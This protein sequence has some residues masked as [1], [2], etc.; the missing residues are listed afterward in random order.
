M[1]GQKWR[2]LKYI[3]CSSLNECRIHNARKS[4]EFWPSPMANWLVYIWQS[5]SSR[6]ADRARSLSV[7]N[8]PRPENLGAANLSGSETSILSQAMARAKQLDEEEKAE[9]IGENCYI[10]NRDFVA[11][12]CHT[13]QANVR[14]LCILL[15]WPK[16][17]VSLLQYN[18]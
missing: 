11:S 3:L 14:L 6:A 10:L 2:I 1:D 8:G 4:T 18:F 16:R 9:R 13:S 5:Q 15:T 7:G 12:V 17:H